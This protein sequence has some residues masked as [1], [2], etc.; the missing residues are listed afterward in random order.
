MD[1]RIE[2]YREL[3]KD[4]KKFISYKIEIRFEEWKNVIEKRYSELFFLHEIMK[5]IKNIIKM[6]IPTFPSKCRIKQIFNKFSD[7]D[8][9]KR[10]NDLEIY[11][12]VLEKTECAKHSKFFPDFFGLPMQYREKWVLSKNIK[13]RNL[14]FSNSLDLY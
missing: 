9:E 12:I 1:I 13:V 4:K 10:K 11:L 6:P 5:L 7:D 14:N 3:E 2:S 8:V